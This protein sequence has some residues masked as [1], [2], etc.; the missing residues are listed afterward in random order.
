MP[1]VFSY[2][3]GRHPQENQDAVR[4]RSHPRHPEIMLCALAD[5]QGGQKGGA[6]AAER[7]CDACIEAAA[8][9]SS[10]ELGS[11]DSWA[12]IL[13]RADQAVARDPVAG[14][15]TLVAFCVTAERVIGGSC[16]D[17]A[18]VLVRGPGD[19]EILTADQPKNP[20]IGSGK[21][22]FG[23]F[24][25][26]LTRSWALVAVSDGV[27]KYTGWE[28]LLQITNAKPGEQTVTEMLNGAQMA[29]NYPPQ[30]DFTILIVTE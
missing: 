12:E 27:W 5:G 28:P 29:L 7:A 20:P 21:A 10:V 18:A 16:G 19:G 30:D 22:S 11:S 24:Q 17:S 23:C 6:A 2:T 9:R 3:R 15:T 25:A 1:K 14:F 4:F 8:R 26:D 13:K